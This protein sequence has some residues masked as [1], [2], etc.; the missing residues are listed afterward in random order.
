MQVTS[1]LLVK[2]SPQVCSLT[3]FVFTQ[4]Y[5]RR[6]WRAQTSPRNVAVYE[7]PSLVIAR[8]NTLLSP[9]TSRVNSQYPLS[10]LSAQWT[11]DGYS[12]HFPVSWAKWVRVE[13]DH[14]PPTA[15]ATTFDR[16]EVPGRRA[17]SHIRAE[18]SRV[19]TSVQYNNI[20]STISN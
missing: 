16:Q 5:T 4:N 1:L 19:V 2:T 12:H 11:N 10:G 17:A 7:F 15:L 13:A 8:P 18:A 3:I 14:L 20:H 9:M 6:A